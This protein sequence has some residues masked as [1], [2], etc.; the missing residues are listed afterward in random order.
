MTSEEP[1]LCVKH[2]RIDCA[3]LKDVDSVLQTIDC[4]IC[5]CFLTLHLLRMFTLFLNLSTDL[6]KNTQINTL[7]RSRDVF[8]LNCLKSI[9]HSTISQEFTLAKDSRKEK[10]KCLSYLGS[11]ECPKEMSIS[12]NNLFRMT[13]FDDGISS[14]MGNTNRIFTAQR[15]NLMIVSPTL[16]VKRDI[17]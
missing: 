3:G 12:R 2:E 13:S 8:I 4:S 7:Y 10:E 15:R 5:H 16:V 14:K 17:I 9:Q 6:E 11:T 1:E